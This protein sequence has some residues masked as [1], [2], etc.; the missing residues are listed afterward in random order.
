MRRVLTILLL[1]IALMQDHAIAGPDQLTMLQS[2]PQHT[3]VYNVK[4]M[5]RREGVSFS[6]QTDGPVRSTPALS[7]G[8]LYF[9]S[10]DGAFYAVDASTGKERWHFKTGGAVHSSPALATL[11]YCSIFS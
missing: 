7:N 11:D 3:G 6:F 4:P 9:G 10:G 1:A 8:I 5:Y 2:N